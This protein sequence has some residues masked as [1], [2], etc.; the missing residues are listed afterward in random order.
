MNKQDK[1]FEKALIKALTLCCEN[2]KID[3]EGFQWLTHSLNFSNIEQ[4]IKVICVFD[5]NDAINNAI[6]HDQI[7]YISN[8]LVACLKDLGININKP[9]KH[10]IFDSE[11]NCDLSHAGNWQKRLNQEY[12]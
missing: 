4:S 1:K 11:E 10:I 12:N 8:V 3:V 9:A 2:F 6:T 5:T 7:T